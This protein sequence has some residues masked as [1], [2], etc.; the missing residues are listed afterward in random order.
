LENNNN[1]N[2]NN[3][4]NSVSNNSS[5]DVKQNN[6][7]RKYKPFKKKYC[8]F[9]SEGVVWI[10]YKNIERLEQYI[11][12]KGKIMS[13]KI[14]GNCAKHQRQVATAIKVMRNLALMPYT[15]T[16]YRSRSLRKNSNYEGQKSFK[17]NLNDN[18]PSS[19]S[20][21]TNSSEDVLK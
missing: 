2:N 4:N 9:C 13:G 20:N 16:N 7:Q 12:D 6:F 18:K 8:K 21:I 11:T 17:E 5:S 3:V 10:D 19:T 15:A 14:T 1:N